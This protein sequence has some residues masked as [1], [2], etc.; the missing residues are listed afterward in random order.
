V[1]LDPDKRIVGIKNVTINEHYFQGHFPG[2]PLMP[3]VLIIEA[4]AQVAGI[5]MLKAGTN[6]RKIAYFMSAD[7]VK[8]RKPVTPGDTLIIEV[9]LTK[10]RA[11]K[12]GRAQGR[13]LVDNEIGSEAEL[14]CS[15]MDRES[16][17]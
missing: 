16:A 11:N 15:I 6:T 2:A 1:E 13:I 10:A 5:P 9:E 4:M 14:M 12:I 3:G 7:K 8:F 17:S